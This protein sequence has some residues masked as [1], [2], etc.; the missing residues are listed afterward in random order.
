MPFSLNYFQR[1]V[2]TRLTVFF[3]T[4]LEI[5]SDSYTRPGVISSRF[6]GWVPT[7]P[8]AAVNRIGRTVLK[9]PSTGRPRRARPSLSRRPPVA[10]ETRAGTFGA[11]ESSG[12][13][14][15][16]SDVRGSGDFCAR[17]PKVVASRFARRPRFVYSRR[18]R[19]R[20]DVVASH[21][22]PI[23]KRRIFGTTHACRRV[24]R[25][26]TTWGIRFRP[27]DL[28]L[29]STWG[30]FVGKIQKKKINNRLRV[31][32]LP[33]YAAADESR[34]RRAPAHGATRT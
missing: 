4:A 22:Q 15:V 13:A 2:M 32:P 5:S 19:R 21:D 25:R 16:G 11:R 8:F 34:V 17:K 9:N 7:R 3:P 23:R 12:N 14:H 24:G 20:N 28:H 29:F 26:R 1:A 10:I 27:F 30:A 6:D 31:E 18:R 33:E